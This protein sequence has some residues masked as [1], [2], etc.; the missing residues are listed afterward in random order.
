MNKLPTY[1]LNLAVAVILGTLISI[2]QQLVLFGLPIRKDPILLGEIVYATIYISLY[3]LL[4]R[5]QF[6]VFPPITR[7]GKVSSSRIMLGFGTIQVLS[8]LLLFL[9]GILLILVTKGTTQIKLKDFAQ[10]RFIFVYYFFINFI[11]YCIAIGIHLYKLYVKEKDQK[12]LAEKSFMEAQLQMLRQQLNPH[13][14][15][16]NLN[17]IAST[18][19]TNPTVAYDF[20]KNMANFYRKV[21]ESE[22]TG[23]I[24]LEEELKTIRYYLHLLS[25]RFEDKL[26]TEINISKEDAGQYR[27]PEFVLQPIIENIIKHNECSRSKPLLIIIEIKQPN[28][29]LVKN[30]YQPKM[31]KEDGL[32]VGWFNIESRYK[33]LGAASPVKYL[34][35]DWFCVEVPLT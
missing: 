19:K 16:N 20:T 26:K 25:V 30:N 23:W 32:G 17:I 27:I 14:L 7:S 10:L 35:G 15:F 1:F 6:K 8:F 34:D 11:F 28:M 12:H 29:L 31:N 3:L 4:V 2:T 24:T 18:I 9:I 5:M 33:H 13:F 21:L 22:N